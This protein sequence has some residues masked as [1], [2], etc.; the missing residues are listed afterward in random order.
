MSIAETCL[1]VRPSGN[2]DCIDVVD[3]ERQNILVVDGINDGVG[4]DCHLMRFGRAVD[5]VAVQKATKRLQRCLELGVPPAPAFTAK[6]GVP[7]KPKR[8]YRLNARV[9]AD[10]HVAELRAVTLVENDHDVTVVDP[11]ALVGRR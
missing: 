5:W 4:M 1:S 11:V 8:L 3:T 10:V 6:I 9:I 7:V 2:L